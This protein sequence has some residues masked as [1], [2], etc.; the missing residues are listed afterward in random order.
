MKNTTITVRRGQIYKVGR[1]T[2][3]ITGISRGHQPKATYTR[4]AAG[5]GRKYPGRYRAWLTWRDGAWRLPW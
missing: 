5:S 3:K 4:V 1:K 2:I